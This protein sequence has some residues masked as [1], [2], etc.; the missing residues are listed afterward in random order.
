M[1]HYLPLPTLPSTAARGGDEMILSCL[2][3]RFWFS[4][5]LSPGSLLLLELLCR[6]FPSPRLLDDL[7][8][9]GSLLQGIPQSWELAFWFERL[10][11]WSCYGIP[12]P[13]APTWVW[14]DRDGLANGSCL[15]AILSTVYMAWASALTMLQKLGK[16]RL[17]ISAIPSEF[18]DGRIPCAV[19]SFR[20]ICKTEKSVGFFW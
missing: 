14:E 6:R 10:A 2:T 18:E 13:E 11:G 3:R 5:L 16:G 1:I 12:R 17:F 7:A 9:S 4:S 15:L 19:L 8:P 20:A